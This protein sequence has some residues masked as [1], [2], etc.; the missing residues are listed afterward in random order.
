MAI[1]QSPEQ[2]KFE[3]FYRRGWAYLTVFPPRGSGRPVYPEDV[4]NRMKVLDVPRVRGKLIRDIV[5]T[6]SGEAVPLV[7]WPGGRTLAAELRVDIAEDRMSAALTVQAPKKGAAPPLEEELLEALEAAGVRA[8]IDRDALRSMLE[9]RTYGV[10]VPVAAGKEPVFGR[11]HRIE[12]RFNTNRGKPYLEM[13][14]GRINLRELNFVD[15]RRAGDLLAELVPPVAAVDGR[16]VTGELI[17]AE[18]DAETV[19][20]RAGSNTR[21]SEDGTKLYAAC[22]GNVRL[23]GSTVLVEPVLSVKNVNYE[24]GNIRFDGTVVIEGS[25]ADGFVVEAGGDIQVG[26]S[27]GK[28]TLSASGSI[29]LKTGING[30]GE[31]SIECGGDLF[32]KY[33]ERCSVRCGG[34]VLV[35]EA[36][37]HCDLSAGRHCVLN[38]RRSEVIGGDLVVGRSFWCKKL[39]NFNEAP[40]RLSVGTDPELVR[41]YRSTAFGLLKT[42]EDLDKAEHQLELV[43]KL[44]QDGREEEKVLQARIQ[45]RSAL[46]KLGGELAALKG[47]APQLRE[48]LRPAKGCLAVVEE[49]M[50]KGATVYFGTLEL[51]V[52]DAGLRRMILRA[53]EKDILESGFNYHERPTLNFE[54]SEPYDAVL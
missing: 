13:D 33:L 15:N 25:I 30:N 3:L 24:T 22:D 2:G 36:V 43:E 53:G 48:Q 19:A 17:P 44:I 8:G 10:A 42:Q 31:G 52:P 32:A 41:T 47:R 35:E 18:T 54:E 29:L 6:A 39:G 1:T 34:N 21:L 9:R 4:E 16:R 28:A 27:V 7:E 14:F 40:T 11:G 23:S 12:Y 5:E 50:F 38:G 51:R 26:S 49:E 45:L 20:L 46:E 37:M